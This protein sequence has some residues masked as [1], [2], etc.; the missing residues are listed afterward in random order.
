MTVSRGITLVTCGVSIWFVC[1]VYGTAA[2]FALASV[3]FLL[4]D[5]LDK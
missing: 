5:D 3:Q 4:M 2:G 1:S